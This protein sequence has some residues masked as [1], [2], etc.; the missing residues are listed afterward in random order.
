MVTISAFLCLSLYYKEKKI[1][2]YFGWS[3]SPILYTRWA[4]GLGNLKA[5]DSHRKWLFPT[6]SNITLYTRKDPF[7]PEFT[8]TCGSHS[9]SKVVLPMNC[10]EKQSLQRE[11]Y[12][13]VIYHYKDFK[14]EFPWGWCQIGR[15]ITF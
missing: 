15:F 2:S 9:I 12:S 13:L 11:Y 6:P 14:N 10:E 5:Y 7:H 1:F 3:L 4:L 8:N